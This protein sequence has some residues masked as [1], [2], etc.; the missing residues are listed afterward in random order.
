[1]GLCELC[2]G[3]VLEGSDDGVN[4]EPIYNGA[5][6]NGSSVS[7]LLFDSVTK[8]YIRVT[9]SGKRPAGPQIGPGGTGNGVIGLGATPA[10]TS[11]NIASFEVYSA[12]VSLNTIQEK[13]E[14]YIAKDEVRSPLTNQL[15]NSLEQ[16][17][18]HEEKGH[19]DQ[20]IKSLND[21]L[22]HMNN[23]AHKDNISAG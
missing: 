5:N 9:M 8:R 21:F 1:M 12:P 11:F 14:K 16:A 18:H 3:M 20:A 17:I 19:H 23:E 7:D 4:W 13:L 6:L 10:S 22:K 15:G 2:T